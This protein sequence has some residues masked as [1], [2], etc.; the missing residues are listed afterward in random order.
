[1]SDKMTKNDRLILVFE[2]ETVA[3]EQTK[4]LQLFYS[5]P[6]VSIRFYLWII[7]VYY[8]LQLSFALKQKLQAHISSKLDFILPVIPQF[9]VKIFEKFL[10]CLFT[11][12]FISASCVLIC[13][14][15]VQENVSGLKIDPRYFA[16]ICQKLVLH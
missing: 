2:H 15:P 8:S 1:M 10:Y 11:K 4:V 7:A 6:R 12:N 13:I 14:E 3:R 16:S 5:V 9:S